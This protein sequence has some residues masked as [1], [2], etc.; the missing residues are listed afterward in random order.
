MELF[1]EVMGKTCTIYMKFVEEYVSTCYDSLA[2]F[3]CIQMVQRLQ[4]LC[5]KRAVPALDFYY[6]SLISILWPRFEYLV[7]ANIQSVRDCDPS[8]LYSHIDTR[9]HYVVRRYAE[10]T[11]AISAIHEHN[12]ITSAM[13]WTPRLHHLLSTMQEEVEGFTLRLAAAFTKRKDQLV[14]LINNYDLMLSV[15]TVR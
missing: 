12:S 11:S 6:E 13:D 15:M 1:Q 5:H 2:L 9:P 4:Y 14:A 7:Q 3:L 10:Y 8:R